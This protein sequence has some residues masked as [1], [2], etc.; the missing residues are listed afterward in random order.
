MVRVFAAELAG[1]N[2]RVN[3]LSPGSVN[4]PIFTKAGFSQKQ[5]DGMGDF[6]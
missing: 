2:I 3:A 6:C 1:R 5:S 4:T